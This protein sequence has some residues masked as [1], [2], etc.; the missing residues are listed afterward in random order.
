[1]GRDYL[2][3]LCVWAYCGHSQNEANRIKG[4]WG[5]FQLDSAPCEILSDS[6]ERPHIEE[7]GP[8]TCTRREVDCLDFHG[9]PHRA[10][11]SP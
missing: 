1:M 9:L 7:A 3:H 4:F 6:F 8:G 10:S 11:A 5:A 2:V